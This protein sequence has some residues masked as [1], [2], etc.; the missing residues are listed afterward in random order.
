MHLCYIDEAG[1]RGKDLGS[2]QQPVFVMAGLLVSDEKWKKTERESQAIVKAACGDVLPP[3]FELHAGDL[4][5]PSGQGPFA[6]WS[7]GVRNQL[8]IDLLQLLDNRSHQVLIQFVHKPRMAAAAVP[9]V[10]LAVDWK[11]PWEVAF[12]SLL[13]MTEEFLRSGRTGRSSTGMVVIDHEPSYLQ[14]VRSHARDRQLTT[15]WKE[16]RKVMEIGYSAVSHA[17]PMIQLADLIAFTMK[18]WAMSEAG[19]GSAWPSPA[20]TFFKQCY[21]IVWPRVEF[22][23]LRFSKLNVP[24]VFTNYLKDVR[25]LR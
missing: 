2:M 14:V 3:G 25:R 11:D 23:M 19:Y 20:H 10:P 1:S 17:N 13:T 24:E 16:T 5:A 7:R 8:A 4:L 9:S 15:G 6:G 22:K 12:A 21:D 18:K